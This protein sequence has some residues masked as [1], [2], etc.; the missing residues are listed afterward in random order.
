[1]GLTLHFERRRWILSSGQTRERLDHHQL[2]KMKG[3]SVMI[4]LL[5]TYAAYVSAHGYMEL[6]AARNCMW[7]FGFPNPKDYNDN[8]CYC[9]GLTRQQRNH[10]A[11]GVCGDPADS[12]SQP[13]NDGGHWGNKIIA[14]TY[15]KG[16]VIDIT[17]RL[18]TSHKG[19]FEFRVGDFSN[20]KT[21]GDSIG[22]LQGELM[23]LVS[24]GTKFVV[25]TFRKGLYKTQ[26][27]LPANLTCKRCVVQWWYRGGNNW[28]CDKDGCGQGHGP[29]EHFVNCADVTI[30]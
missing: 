27:R 24:G 12:A 16:Q 9:G 3:L 6:P 25:P 28:G 29:Q 23:E 5:V 30:N 1:M 15:T 8:Q 19:T 4:L 17:V 14:Q 20:S 11:C 18:T 26:V 21:A 22:K 10:G 13:H 7:R 2:I